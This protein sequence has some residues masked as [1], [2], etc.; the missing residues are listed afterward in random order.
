MPRTLHKLTDTFA[1]S[2]RLDPGR[3]S[4]GG[5]LYLNVKPGGSKSWIFMF[6]REGKRRVAGLGPYPTVK[7][8]AARKKADEYRTIVAD[9]GDPIDIARK[10]DEP[11]FAE[12][13]DMF[14]E[15]MER[16]WRNEKHR[17]QWRMTL[18]DAYCAAIR[19]K[20]V[21]KIDTNDV[22]NVLNPI[23]QTKPETASRIRG[24][25]E[26]VLDYAKAR[27]W[28][29]GENPALWRGHLKSILPARQ[30][31][32]R[33]HHS[34]M[35]Y[36]EVPLFVARLR[37]MDAMAARALEFLILTAARSGEVL[38]ARWDEL[39]FDAE[40]WTVPAHR[41]KAGRQHRVPLSASAMAIVKALSRLKQSEFVFP[42]LRPGKALSVM[43]MTM[44]MRRMNVGQYTV[45]GF[46]S[47]F[48]D[49][50]GEE[51]TFARELGEA[52]LAHTVGDLTERAYRRGDAIEKR[53][54]MMIAWDDFC[55]GSKAVKY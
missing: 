16:Q 34:A 15:S 47:A 31:L 51:T 24:R 32:S 35:P 41:M 4:D 18:G 19:S 40:I 39:D 21:S 55:T 23:W 52:A 37:D 30:R 5:G 28:R 14:L 8:S 3:Y 6:N 7:L 22:L 29:T 36:Q 10:P 1:R 25:I 11:T 9:G 27:G 12:G 26:R 17:A 49:W 13:A 33:G 2:D 53:R 48:R 20:R 38:G 54:K 50:A 46:R 44:Q 43:A 42:G 45:H